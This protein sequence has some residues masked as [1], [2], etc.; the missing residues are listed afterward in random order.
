MEK[1]LNVIKV[2]LLV[3]IVIYVIQLLIPSKCEVSGCPADATSGSDYCI[4]HKCANSS[5]D[6]R[7]ILEAE[8]GY[9]YYCRECL[10]EA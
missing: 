8:G 3:G 5:C 6:N 7:A 2:I 1:V 10:D 4:R 9:L